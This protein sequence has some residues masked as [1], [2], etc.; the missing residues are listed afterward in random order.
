MEV[1]KRASRDLESKGRSQVPA[2]NGGVLIRKSRRTKVN[3]TGHGLLTKKNTHARSG[4]CR[5]L[6]EIEGI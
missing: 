5:T 6:I 3:N 2:R 1:G 4:H